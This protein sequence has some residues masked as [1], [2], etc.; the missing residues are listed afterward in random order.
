MP[1]SVSADLAQSRL[2]N[3]SLPGIEGLHYIPDYV[4]AAQQTRLL[5]DLIRSKSSWIQVWYLRA[6]CLSASAAYQ[7]RD[8][9]LSGRKLQTYGGTVHD[10]WGGLLKAP[11]PAW[12]QAHLTR[13]D[14]DF[15]LYQGPA[16][17]VLLNAY[18]P[19]QGILV[20]VPLHAFFFHVCQTCSQTEHACVSLASC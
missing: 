18:E 19:G 6:G 12:L 13:I 17:H 11:M 10:K 3:S 4:D 5:N 2:N 1:D 14:S 15:D 8:L 16:N 7:T 9:Q 20:W